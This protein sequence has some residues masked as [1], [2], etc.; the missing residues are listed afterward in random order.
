MGAG[1][2]SCMARRWDGGWWAYVRYL[3][4]SGE[5]AAGVTVLLRRAR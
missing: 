3:Y 4:L 5:S 2:D 1:G